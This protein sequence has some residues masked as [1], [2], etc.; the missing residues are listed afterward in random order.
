MKLKAQLADVES[1]FAG[2]R[3]RRGTWRSWLVLI[4]HKQGR[5]SQKFLITLEGT[6]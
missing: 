3:I 5:Y 1:A 2:A 4:L 6:R